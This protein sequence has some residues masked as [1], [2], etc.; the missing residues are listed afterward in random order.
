MNHTPTPHIE[1]KLGEIFYSL[2]EQKYARNSVSNHFSS[3][4]LLETTFF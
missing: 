3:K 1:A 4:K 2:P